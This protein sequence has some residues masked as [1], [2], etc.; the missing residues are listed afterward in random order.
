VDRT[1]AQALGEQAAA[2]LAS[3]SSSKIGPG[4]TEDEFARIERRHAFT[5][6]D[7]HRAFLAAGLPTGDNWPDWRRGDPD[8]LEDRLRWP[9]DGLLFDVAHNGF[10]LP[11]WGIRP[12]DVTDA[13]ILAE[14][15]MATV[16]RLVP[17]Y[18][19]R[20]LPAGAGTFGHP[21]LSVMQTDIIV[22]GSDLADYVG[23]EFAH[24]IPSS[25]WAASA[26]SPSLATVEFWRDLVD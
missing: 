9:V 13:V 15:R 19:H 26:L 1:E 7:D 11:A 3:L 6:A 23:R 12:G 14:R 24:T 17:V 20:Y 22:Y 10:W 8:D 2:V 18:G 21:V 16:P 4:L 25:S 5:F